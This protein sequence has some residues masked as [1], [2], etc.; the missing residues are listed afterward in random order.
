MWSIRAVATIYSGV[1]RIFKGALALGESI[2]E[3]TVY[4]QAGREQV[5]KEK[6]SLSGRLSDI[7]R[8]RDASEEV[9]IANSLLERLR[10]FDVQGYADL[11][12]TAED[13][14]GPR[15]PRGGSGPTTVIDQLTYQLQRICDSCAV[16]VEMDGKA[17]EGLEYLNEEAGNLE[18]LVADILQCD[19]TLLH[20][21]HLRYDP[22]YCPDTSASPRVPRTGGKRS[23]R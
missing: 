21:H 19:E 10:Q 18:K 2:P 15:V 22:P 17:A 23:S 1:K 16:G 5:L 14:I 12:Q 13:R 20:E 6:R 7:L 4:I 3:Q 8:N 9:T 11:I